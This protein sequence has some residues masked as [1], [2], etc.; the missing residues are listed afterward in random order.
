MYPRNYVRKKLSG[1]MRSSH[2]YDGKYDD[3]ILISHLEKLN[4][5]IV[6][7]SVYKASYTKRKY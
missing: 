4:L 1:V 3:N 6:A 7:E 2:H 5:F